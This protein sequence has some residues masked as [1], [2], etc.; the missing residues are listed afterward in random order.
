MI[1][2]LSG[3]IH[4]KSNE[5]IIL[6]TGG[7]GYLVTI[8]PNYL[9]LLKVSVP[10]ELF[11]YT[12]VREDTLD[13]YGFLTADELKLFKLVLTVSGVGPKT[14]L[15]VIDKGVGKVEGA[16]KNA[17]TDFFTTVPRLGHKN[18]Q[19][20]I[21]ELKNKLGG[22]KELDLTSESEEST[23]AIEALRNLGYTRQEATQSIQA[24]PASE[25]TLEQKISYALRQLGKAK[26][27]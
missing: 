9:S 17:D 3:S 15:L 24:V 26:S 22:L 13:L 10:A 7:V 21:I 25:K 18:A 8:P 1:G 27:K 14:A 12:H 19:K 23:E 6:L 5:Q 4:S 2:F 16:I 20:I 11:I